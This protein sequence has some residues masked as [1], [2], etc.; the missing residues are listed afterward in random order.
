MLRAF[1]RDRSGGYEPSAE[2]D[3]PQILQRE[4]IVRARQQFGVSAAF[5]H[6]ELTRQRVGLALRHKSAYLF[7]HGFAA[8]QLG[9]ALQLCGPAGFASEKQR[10]IRS[11]K[12][13]GD[14]HRPEGEP[15]RGRHRIRQRQLGHQIGAAF[16]SRP[17]PDG[18]IRY[19]RFSALHEIPAHYHG[20]AFK[21][22]RPH[23][24]DLIGMSVVKRIIFGYNYGCFHD[25]SPRK[26]FFLDICLLL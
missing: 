18:F 26:Q 10:R 4:D 17:R 15:F 12:G 7:V 21:A 11:G 23:G 5:Q 24:L 9:R 8:E 14:S 22:E 19:R 2:Y 20:D 1:S 6:R 13:V 3:P 25:F 16:Q